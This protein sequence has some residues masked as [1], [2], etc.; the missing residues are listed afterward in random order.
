VVFVPCADYA[1]YAFLKVLIIITG[2]IKPRLQD[3]HHL[4]SQFQY[5]QQLFILGLP[6]RDHFL[7]IIISSSDNVSDV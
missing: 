6:H 3:E 5:E 7:N 4:V 2:L 1:P